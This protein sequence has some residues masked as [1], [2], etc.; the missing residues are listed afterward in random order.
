VQNLEYLLDLLSGKSGQI[1][2]FLQKILIVE[3]LAE[4]QTFSHGKGGGYFKFSNEFFRWQKARRILTFFRFFSMV[5]LLEN[6]QFCNEFPMNFSHGEVG[7][8]SCVHKMV[9]RKPGRHSPYLLPH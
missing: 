4:T 3:Y 8:I 5:D 2:A 9:E 1:F 7:V 6:L